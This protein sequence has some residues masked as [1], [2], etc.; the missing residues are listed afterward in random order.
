VQKAQMQT[1]QGQHLCVLGVDN[2]FDFCQSCVQQILNDSKLQEEFSSI[3]P[4]LKLISANSINWACFL[5]QVVFTISSYL[6]LV[7]QQAIKLGD[8]VDICVPIGNFGNILSCVCARRLGLPIRCLITASNENN[9]NTNFVR[10]GTYDMREHQFN[11]T[12]SS[13]LERFLYLVTNGDH[14]LIKTLFE[15]LVQNQMF[16]VSPD[17]HKKIQEEIQLG[18]TS[19]EECFK[20]IDRVYRK[21][22]RTRLIDPH[23]AVA[24]DVA[25]KYSD[26]DTT[27]KQIPMLILS[28]AHYAKFPV[29][30]MK[31]FNIDYS[32]STDTFE[33]MFT[34][35]NLH[36]AS[37]SSREAN[38]MHTELM[39]LMHK[40]PTHT[41]CVNGNKDEVIM[42]IKKML[43]K[44]FH[45]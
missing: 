33:S 37:S 3:L 23:T 45:Y 1:A 5:P 14:K 4:N 27:E 29:T 22:N 7:E 11:K 10:T 43:E 2:D 19:D 18:W 44:A 35:L 42:E 39:K 24:I 38:Q 41:T 13:N 8:P 9:V 26:S 30:M 17:L 28:T 32:P 16:T 31:A 12:V 20:I 6:K 25:L 15:S 40:K 36:L 21:T 34:K